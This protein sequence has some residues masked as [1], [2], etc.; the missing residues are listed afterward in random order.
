MGGPVLSEPKSVTDP[1]ETRRVGETFSSRS[2]VTI[3]VRR[4]VGRPGLMKHN[5]CLVTFIR[6]L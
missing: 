1:N 5:V 6:K 4:T 2:N 3:G